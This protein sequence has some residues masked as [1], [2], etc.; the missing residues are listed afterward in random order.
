MTQTAQS[1]RIPKKGL[2]KEIAPSYNTNWSRCGQAPAQEGA[3]AALQRMNT[4]SMMAGMGA[5]RGKRICL[6]IPR[7][8]GSPQANDLESPVS[9]G[10]RNEEV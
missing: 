4:L 9:D 7:K 1:A 6:V 10:A 2:D 8:A 5:G 3:A